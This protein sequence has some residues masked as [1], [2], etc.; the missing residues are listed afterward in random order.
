MAPHLLDDG[1]D[2]LYVVEYRVGSCLHD[3][4]EM[5]ALSMQNRWPDEA[6]GTLSPGR[7]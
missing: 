2:R 6:D 4:V 5:A 1:R 7:G 3:V